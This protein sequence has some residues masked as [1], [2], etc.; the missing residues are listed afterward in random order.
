MADNDH[1]NF[2]AERREPHEAPAGWARAAI[3]SAMLGIVLLAT[4]PSMIG[5][6][7]SSRSAAE[8]PPLLGFVRGI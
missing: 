5:H 8:L 4:V 3:M 1:E 6:P 7:S 2:L